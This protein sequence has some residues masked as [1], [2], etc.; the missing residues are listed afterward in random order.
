M[1]VLV[2]RPAEKALKTGAL[3][4]RLGHQPVALPLFHT[5]HDADGARHALKRQSWAAL[6]ATSTEALKDLDAERDAPAL[7]DRPL[8]AVGAETAHAALAAGFTRIFT[9]TGNGEALAEAIA[10]ERSLFSKTPLLYLAGS[11]RA[12]H[13]ERRLAALGVPFETVAVYT[14]APIDHAASDLSVAIQDA[15][16]ILFYS[17]MTAMRFFALG[18]ANILRES[19]SAPL[20]LCL[21]EN[22]AKAVPAAFAGAVRIAGAPNEESLLS[23]LP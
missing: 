20:F 19:A 2:T 16:A 14:M 13:L 17:Q 11:L 5:V 8:F 6:A 3:L 15:D 21:S 12:P 22:V 1:R 23:L 18:A 10:A 4:E 9:G 7:R